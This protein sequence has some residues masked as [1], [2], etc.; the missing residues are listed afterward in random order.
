MAEKIETRGT[1]TGGKNLQNLFARIF[2]QPIM[3]DLVEAQIAREAGELADVL[4]LTD[5]QLAS[6]EEE[7]KKR[8]EPVG[9]GFRP[10]SPRPTRQQAAPETSLEEELASILT[11]EQYQKYQEYT[12]KKNAL[13][14][15]SQYPAMADIASSLYQPQINFGLTPNEWYYTE[16]FGPDVILIHCPHGTTE[17][18]RRHWIYLPQGWPVGDG[19]TYPFGSLF[20]WTTSGPHS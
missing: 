9:P 8:R 19:S 11:P 3:E 4:D 7:L 2:S 5:E 6:V 13:A 18:E 1:K 14:G 15:S 16:A 20:E 10:S 17:A 12:E